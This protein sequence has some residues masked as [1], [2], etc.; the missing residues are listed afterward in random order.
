MAS[1]K[2]EGIDEFVNLCIFTDRQLANLIKRAIGKGGEVMGD[3][4]G[5]V[6]RGLPVDDSSHHHSR[7]TSI[8][9]RQKDGLVESY[10]I[11]RVREKRWGWN[12]KIGFDGYNDIVTKRWPKGQPNAMVARSL[13]SGTSFLQKNPFMDTTVA[14]NEAATVEAIEQEFDKRLDR[15]WN[16]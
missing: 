7:R 4:I 5:S 16:K 3:A 8:T 6:V 1:W 13:N 12:V 10:G 14:A 9:S 11:A 2:S 15:L